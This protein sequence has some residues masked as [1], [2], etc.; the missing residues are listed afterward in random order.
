MWAVGASG[1]PTHSTPAR[2]QKGTPMT[3]FLG[4][5]GAFAQKRS[6]AR[7]QSRPTTSQTQQN[8]RMHGQ[9]RPCA[10]FGCRDDAS[11]QNE[12]LPFHP[13]S[14][15][16]SP[17]LQ[18]MRKGRCAFG[19]GCRSALLTLFFAMTGLV[20]RFDSLCSTFSHEAIEHE[21]LAQAKA[22]ASMQ[23]LF[24]QRP[25]SCS[26]SYRTAKVTRPRCGIQPQA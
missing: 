22:Q 20:H 5:F 6:P 24:I 19:R 11:L 7:P 25:R 16:V 21:R 15:L 8:P 13:R 3:P 2:R 23:R 1:A 14:V 9:R 4:V 12:L 10:F 26:P 18:Y 17:A